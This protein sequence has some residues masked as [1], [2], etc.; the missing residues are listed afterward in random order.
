MKM[1]KL[2]NLEDLKSLPKTKWNISQPLTIND[3]EDAFSQGLSQFISD[4]S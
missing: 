2:K 3:R 4:V 1:V